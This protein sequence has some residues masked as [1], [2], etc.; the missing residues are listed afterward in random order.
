VTRGD[1][2]FVCVAKLVCIG[3]FM[4]ANEKNKEGWKV[5][6]A[7]SVLL[8]FLGIIYIWSV[9]VNPVSEFYAWEVPKVKLTSSFMLCFYVAG[10]LA[11]GR[12]QAKTGAG[13]I[14][15]AGSLM[16]AAG[17]L[18]TAFLTPP[19]A[20][21]IYVTYGIIGGFGVGAA[22]NTIISAAQQW[23]PKNR[24][25]ALGIAVS[26][27]GFS[28]VI[29]APL[30]EAL[31]ARFAL[32]NTFLILAAA[33]SLA[34]LFLFRFIRLPDEGAPAQAE[35]PSSQN[36]SAKQ[37]TVIEA[38]KTKEFYYITFSMMLATAAYFVLNPSFKTFAAERGFGG[39][40]GTVIVM[41][42]GVTNTLGRL[43]APLM[44]DKIGR[45]KAA[46]TIVLA[47][48]ICAFL[49]CFAQ[50]AMFMISV[51]VIAFCYGGYAGIYPALTADHFGVN[52][53]GS[54]Y[55]AVMLGFAFS[56]LGFPMIIALIDDVTIKF[57][58]LASLSVIGVLLLV[59]LMS[60]KK[61]E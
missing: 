9:F 35:L 23:F 38:I 7:G 10:I 50:G 28:T 49:L 59:L 15:L 39:S 51:A 43:I 3:E 26:T 61:K 52:N 20:W 12:L 4:A 46:L 45:E 21:L 41:M 14:V 57:I 36:K 34:A 40:I 18:A 47:T 19:V 53:V 48:A 33:I 11:G 54:N 13:I 31:I 37:Y 5:L 16:L 55:G 22:Y 27:F 24:G 2:N 58:V 17:M 60:A 56:A 32:R 6:I 42:T 29:F 1:A 44:S 30:I 8:L 25:F